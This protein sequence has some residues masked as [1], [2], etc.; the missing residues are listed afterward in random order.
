MVKKEYPKPNKD[1]KKVSKKYNEKNL[2]VAN[3]KVK[4]LLNQ[5]KLGPDG[6]RL[7]NNINNKNIQKNNN[8]ILNNNDIIKKKRSYY[9][10]DDDC[11]SDSFIDDKEEEKDANKVLHFFKKMHKINEQKKKHEYKGEVEVA[12][13]DII[14]EE[15]EI[16]RRIGKIE[17]EIEKKY[18]KEHPDEEEEEEDDDYY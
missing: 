15:E 2:P 11:Y 12:N 5:Y 1:Q 16:T 14:Q 18:N 17:D 6:K 13:Y 4:E 9:D 10:D 3:D 7:N 8:K